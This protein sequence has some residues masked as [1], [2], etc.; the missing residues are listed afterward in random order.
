MKTTWFTR[1]AAMLVLA[2]GLFSSACST[3]ITGQSVRANPTPEMETIAYT[4]EQRQNNLTR[5]S[6][7][8]WRQI[9]D[10][11]DKF[12]LLDQPLHLSNIPIP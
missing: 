8:T 1:G 4:H 6:N 10:D 12:W 7:T 11:W 3:E 9:I 2:T 5:S